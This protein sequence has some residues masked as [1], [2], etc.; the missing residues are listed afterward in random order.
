MNATLTTVVVVG[1]PKPRSRTLQVAV[2]TVTELTGRPPD[3]TIDLCDFGSSLLDDSSAEVANAV[4]RVSCAGLAIIASP[5]YK[6]SYTGLLKLFLDRFAG[7]SLS[8]VVAVPLMVAAS[9]L[10][11]MAGEVFMKPVLAELGAS[12]PTPSVFV[13]EDRLNDKDLLKKWIS[14]ARP[15]L[16]GLLSK[17]PSPDNN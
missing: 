6:A 4:T 8:D 16:H 10:H 5:T 12:M 14:I 7:G 15:R 17:S 2:R 3:T 11:S 13:R 1:N 9:D